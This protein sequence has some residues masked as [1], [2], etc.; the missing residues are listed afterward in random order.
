TLFV[1]TTIQFALT[2]VKILSIAV[3]VFLLFFFTPATAATAPPTH[4]PGMAPFAAVLMAAFWAY[5]GWNNLPMLGGEV[6][7]PQDNLPWALAIGILLVLGVY[8]AL[9]LS[10]F[11]VLSF[12]EVLAANSGSNRLA[13]PVATIAL[14]KSVPGASVKIIA[15]LLTISALGAMSGSILSSARVPYA[16]ATDRVFFAALGRL[17]KKNKTPVAA[18]ATQGDIAALLALSGSFDQLTDSVVF[19]SWIF[20]ALTTAA[21]FKLRRAVST[22]VEPRFK[23]PLYPFLPIVFLLC[24]SAFILYAMIAMPYLT[25]RTRRYRV[26]DSALFLVLEER[27]ITFTPTSPPHPAAPVHSAWRVTHALGL[28]KYL[29]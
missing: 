11:R 20:Y 24:A 3:I 28:L 29:R 5:D 25:A 12:D 6:K 13:E 7:N 9:N 19:A 16:M 1:S 10:F 26:G 18:T 2:I 8:L 14:A 17:S 23:V 27:E 21:I 4:W 15:A 22:G